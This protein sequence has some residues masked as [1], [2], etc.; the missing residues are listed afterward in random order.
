MRRIVTAGILLVL[1]LAGVWS[2]QLS[3]ADAAVREGT[4]EGIARAIELAP[5][6]AAY[7]AMRGLQQE[8]A[9]LDVTESFERVA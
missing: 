7:L 5:G 6:N 2:V 9:G 3:R 8:A 4:D 1:S